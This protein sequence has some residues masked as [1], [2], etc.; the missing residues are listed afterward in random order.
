[1]LT[2]TSTG[3]NLGSDFVGLF[4]EPSPRKP[5]EG[6]AVAAIWVRKESFKIVDRIVTSDSREAVCVELYGRGARLI[7][8]GS[9]IPYHGAKG[10][11]RKS[12]PWQEH[13]RAIE[14]HRRDWIDLRRSFPDHRL[15]AAGDYNQYRD[16]VDQYGTIEIRQM[17]SAALDDAK[18]TCVTEADFVASVGLSR[19]NIDHVCLSNNIAS[20]VSDIQ[21]WEATVAGHTIERPQ[22]NHCGPGRCNGQGSKSLDLIRMTPIPYPD[23]NRFIIR[24]A[25]ETHSMENSNAVNCGGDRFDCIGSFREGKTSPV[26]PVSHNSGSRTAWRRIRIQTCIVKL[27]FEFH[28]VDGR[29][30]NCFSQPY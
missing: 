29:A 19:R 20:A 27:V 16:G 14:W 1:V 30:G 13:K 3:V 21:A 9:I 23:L 4:T 12:L 2:E 8:Y 25:H 10:G 15:I 6:E 17:L 28:V 24:S 7:V 5:R 22:W 18:L 11:D 26:V